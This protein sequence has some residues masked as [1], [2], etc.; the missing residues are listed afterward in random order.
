MSNSYIKTKD[1]Q[2][3]RVSGHQLVIFSHQM[4]VLLI[5]NNN[6]IWFYLCLFH[7]IPL[8]KDK[9][10]DQNST[11][12]A[13]LVAPWCRSDCMD[14]MVC[15]GPEWDRIRKADLNV[16]PADRKFTLSIVCKLPF[17]LKKMESNVTYR[18]EIKFVSLPRIMKHLFIFCYT[19]KLY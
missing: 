8:S 15:R 2:L 14:Q 4:Y 7:E 16:A 3:L 1:F 18:L 13:S 12:P 11:E 9:A 5:S 17:P 6:S 10:Q 19:L